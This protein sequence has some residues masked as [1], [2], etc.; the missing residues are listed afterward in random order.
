[1]FGVISKIC[2]ILGTMYYKAYLKDTETRTVIY[3]STIM[4]VFSTGLKFCFANRWNLQVGVSDIVFLIFTDVVF[5]CLVLATNVLPCLALFAKITPPGIEGTVFAFLTG[6]WNLADT[7]LSPM[8]GAWI[9]KTF[10]GVTAENLKN[11][12]RLCLVQF[13]CSFLGFLLVPLIPTKSDINFYQNERQTT[14]YEPFET[15]EED[16]P[17]YKQKF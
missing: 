9:N 6:T 13:L 10:F 8:V 14:K 11:Y 2:H 5:G 1:M 15:K 7:V 12:P 3:Y 17:G 16:K 4:C